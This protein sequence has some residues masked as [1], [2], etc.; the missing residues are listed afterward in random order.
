[1]RVDALWDDGYGGR[2]VGGSAEAAWHPSSTFWLRGRAIAL[3]VARDDGGE[4]T[5]ARPRYVTTSTVLSTSWRLA[6]G[7]AVHA[8]VE[9][10]HDALHDLQLRAIG[11]FD[12]AFAPEP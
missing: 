3:A 4:G 11:M 2:R 5:S 6:D 10:D 9:T 7:I 12:F 8:I 1:V